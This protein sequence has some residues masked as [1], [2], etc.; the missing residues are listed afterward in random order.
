MKNNRL[1]IGIC[2]G[3][4]FAL[5]NVLV[6]TFANNFTKTFWFAYGFT[7][8][9][10]ILQIVGFFISY[11]RK[12]T[13]NNTFFGLPLTIIGLVYLCVQIVA[14]SILMIYADLSLKVA[15][16]I[17]IIVLAGYIVAC[18]AALFAKNV[19]IEADEKTKDQV[20]FLKLLENDIV[21]LQEKC[22]D[23][24]LS[25]RLENLA[26]LVKYSDPIS[27]PSLSLMEQKIT[28]KINQLIEKAEA[29]KG[30]ESNDICN[31]IELL[32]ADRNRKCKILK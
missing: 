30:L 24:A 27:H 3:V 21:S 7:V 13:P 10:F 2:F 5:Y 12:T 9:A 28:N 19:V 26:E 6:F 1:L 20:L 4:I 29:G 25:T 23:P 22:N 8:L 31:E 32:L 16:I 14:G 15:N 17:Q 11:D 18:S